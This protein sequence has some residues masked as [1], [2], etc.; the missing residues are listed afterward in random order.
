M[1][2]R[3]LKLFNYELYIELDSSSWVGEDKWH[4][5]WITFKLGRI[6]PMEKAHREFLKK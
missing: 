6:T 5:V 3:L 1:E 2:I 4:E